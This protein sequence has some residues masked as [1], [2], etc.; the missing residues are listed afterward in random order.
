MDRVRLT[1]WR[2]PRSA[3]IAA[4]LALSCATA[5]LAHS[6]VFDCFIDGGDKI[7]CE[8][9]FSDGASAAGVTV[10][11]LDQ[12]DRVLIE[13]KIDAEGRFSFSKPTQDYHVHFDAGA[14][15]TVTVFGA[16]ITE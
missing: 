13:G 11:V 1:D 5:S 9:G 10:R 3:A 6:P 12:D 14:G 4:A 7:T 15:H 16:D 2:R 8:G